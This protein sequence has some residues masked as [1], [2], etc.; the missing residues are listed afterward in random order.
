MAMTFI[1]FL[2]GIFQTFL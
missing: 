2:A 1:V